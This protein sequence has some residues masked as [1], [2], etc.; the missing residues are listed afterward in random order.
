MLLALTCNTCSPS[1]HETE[2]SKIQFS[3]TTLELILIRQQWWTKTL[4]SKLNWLQVL[5]C[6]TWTC[7]CSVHR[8]WFSKNRSA[9][10]KGRLKNKKK[11][12]QLKVTVRLNLSMCFTSTVSFSLRSHA[13]PLEDTRR[14]YTSSSAS[15]VLILLFTFERLAG[16]CHD[17]IT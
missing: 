12:A 2:S 17:Y 3:L 5:K 4:M 10:C 11:G 13:S 6:C 9:K 1:F 8:E 7:I 14:I 15:Q 16:V